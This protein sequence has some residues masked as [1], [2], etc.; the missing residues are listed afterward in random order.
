[1][2]KKPSPPRLEDHNARVLRLARDYDKKYRPVVIVIGK[3]Y[4]LWDEQH[5]LLSVRSIARETWRYTDS[6]KPMSERNVKRL[7][8]EMELA[9]VLKPDP[10]RRWNGSQASSVRVL[11]F[12]QSIRLGRPVAH[13]WDAPLPADV[14]PDVTPSDTPLSPLEL[15]SISPNNSLTNS[16]GR[17]RG[18]DHP[19]GER[20][21]E[22]GI[23]NTYSFW[24]VKEA[25]NRSA[26]DAAKGSGMLKAARRQQA[27]RMGHRAS[28]VGTDGAQA[29]E[30]AV[31]RQDR[32][33]KFD[34]PAHAQT[35]TLSKAEATFMWTYFR[36]ADRNGKGEFL[37]SR[38][39]REILMARHD[40]PRSHQPAPARAGG[41]GAG[42]GR[43]GRPARR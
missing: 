21:K 35:V 18:Q 32:P 42:P 36:K 15:S 24:E 9:G 41:Q 12:H 5:S 14:T 43:R 30:W 25:R 23:C 37:A 40:Q 31:F 4:N 8:S 34:P 16:L 20:E 10:R 38:G 26:R 29:R 11:D 33:P 17:E 39:Q 13:L 3:R 7:L 27:G 22:K 28:T 19:G 6:R 2:A 1:M